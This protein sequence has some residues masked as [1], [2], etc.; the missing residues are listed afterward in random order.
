M[1]EGLA[2]GLCHPHLTIK[3]LSKIIKVMCIEVDIDA[4]YENQKPIYAH[5]AVERMDEMFQWL[6]HGTTRK[7]WFCGLTDDIDY[8]SEFH[9]V[10]LENFYFVNCA[11]NAE[12]VKAY[13]ILKG[14]GYASS[15]KV[16]TQLE[17]SYFVYIYEIRK[18]YRKTRQE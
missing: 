4:L 17:D 8:Q 6:G 13:E 2:K 7:D 12:A 15:N 3:K 5:E 10:S 18:R 1:T 11:N 9:K 16:K 14:M